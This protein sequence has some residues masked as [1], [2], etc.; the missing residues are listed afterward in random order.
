MSLI[1]ALS[2]L[3]LAAAAPSGPPCNSIPGWEQLLAGDTSRIIVL[4]ELHGSDE[5]PA[6]LADA[7]CLTGR[8]RPV[9]VAVEQPSSDQP[10]IDAFMESDC[11]EEAREAFLRAHAR[12]REARQ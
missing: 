11:G 8:T 12:P 9:V 6:L 3:L 7:A 5:V 4:G 1:A 10:A 2:P